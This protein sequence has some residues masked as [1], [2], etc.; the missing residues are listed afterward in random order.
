MNSGALQYCARTIGNFWLIDILL[1]QRVL[2]NVNGFIQTYTR[3]LSI[4]HLFVYTKAMTVFL[5]YA[6]DWSLG[7]QNTRNRKQ[8]TTH[9]ML[10]NEVQSETTKLYYSIL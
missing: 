9:C 5:I 1:C 4:R 3:Q 10:D 6:K 8:K 2:N 7:F